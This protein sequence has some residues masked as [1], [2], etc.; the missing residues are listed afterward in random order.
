MSDES[1]HVDLAK[2]EP[3][4]LARMLARFKQLESTYHPNKR[5][6]PQDNAGACA[7]LEANGNFL[8]PWK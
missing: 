7:A 6:P 2:S 4:V 8:R 3:A 1:E 5:N